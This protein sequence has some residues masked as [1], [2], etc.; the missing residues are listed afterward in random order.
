[1]T[2]RFAV[3]KDYIPDAFYKRLIL[4]V[5]RNEDGEYVGSKD[6]VITGFGV[7]NKNGSGAG[8]IDS[9]NGPSDI[10]MSGEAFNITISES[11]TELYIFYT[12]KQQN[13]K[14]FYLLDGTNTDNPDKLV[15]DENDHDHKNGVLKVI[16]GTA[17]Y[18]N[19]TEYTGNDMH[20]AENAEH[21]SAAE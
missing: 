2:E 10:K 18:R 15:F 14:V 8:L 21:C 7:Y 16:S 4:A 5:E 13:Y 19:G 6:N 17:A 9:G 20:I 11:G 12:R 1:M 3:V